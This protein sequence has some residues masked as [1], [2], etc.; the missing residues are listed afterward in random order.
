M[1]VCWVIVLLRLGQNSAV[2]DCDAH[3]PPVSRDLNREP[4]AIAGRGVP[5]RIASQFGCYRRHVVPR[6]T[7]RHESV[8]PF[9]QQAELA[10]LAR[11][12]SARHRCFGRPGI[13]SDQ[14]PL[15]REPTDNRHTSSL[16]L[17]Y[18]RPDPALRGLSCRATAS[19]A[20]WDSAAA[21]RS[22]D[23]RQ[24]PDAP[25]TRPP[26]MARATATS[27]TLGVAGAWSWTVTGSPGVATR[28]AL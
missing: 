4:S 25:A 15:F 21:G 20:T 7:V 17:A 23:A 3:E 22:R 18:A 1:F 13:R 16:L 5:H 8:Q 11:K 14:A 10:L 9:A 6:W 27:I 24:P 12:H 26:T 28:T 19:H 2:G